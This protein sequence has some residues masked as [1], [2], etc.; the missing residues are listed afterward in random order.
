MKVVLAALMGL[1]LCLGGVSAQSQTQGDFF[2]AL[3]DVPV[4]PGLEELHDQAMLFDKPDGRIASVAA[5]SKTVSAAQIAQFYAETLPQ[6]GWEKVS[7]NQYVRDG[8]RLSFEI[9]K[10]PPLTIVHFTLEPAKP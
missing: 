2:E 7:G 6:M 9:V 10:K 5:A 1:A 8:N 4:M 3:Y